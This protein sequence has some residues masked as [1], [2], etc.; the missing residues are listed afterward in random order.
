MQDEHEAVGLGLAEPG[1]GPAA[2]PAP[3]RGHV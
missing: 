1:L 3:H 2:A